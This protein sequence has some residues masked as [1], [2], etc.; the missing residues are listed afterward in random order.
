MMGKVWKGLA[1]L[2][3]GAVVLL[4]GVLNFVRRQRDTARDRAYAAELEAKAERERTEQRRKAD[5]ASAEAKK[6]GDE[7]VKQAVDGARAGRRDHFE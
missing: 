4:L 1:A 5:T 3:G 2:G 7:D 6:Q